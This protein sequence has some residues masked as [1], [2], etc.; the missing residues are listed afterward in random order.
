[1]QN[2][3]WK[4]HFS[5]HVCVCVCVWREREREREKYHQRLQ[6]DQ[7]SPLQH[8]Q[9]VSH[10]NLPLKTFSL[11]SLHIHSWTFHSDCCNIYTFSVKSILC[12]FIVDR[13][14]WSTLNLVKELFLVYLSV[15]VEMLTYSMS[16]TPW[17]I[18]YWFL[19]KK[20][21]KKT[22]P[23]YIYI[24][25]LYCCILPTNSCIKQQAAK[26]CTNINDVHS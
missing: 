25:T 1:M 3:N 4:I 24:Y 9:F 15:N 11:E 16:I 26:Q 20:K 18:S 13:E 19:K 12:N 23:W 7:L 17:Y 2:V 10:K 21:K 8:H 5:M 14:R 22:N 6:T